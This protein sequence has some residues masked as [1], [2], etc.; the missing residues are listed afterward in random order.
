[1]DALSRLPLNDPDLTSAPDQEGTVFM[2]E[3]LENSISPVTLSTIR[4][5]TSKD[6]VL[7][8]VK[9]MV[10]HGNW[11]AAIE[12]EFLPY[13]RRKR[14]LSVLDDCIVWGSRVVVP[15]PSQKAVLE[16]LHEAHP[17]IVRMKSLARGPV[18][19]PGID[20]DLEEKVKSC[21]PCQ[22]NKKSPPVAPLH[23]WEFPGR[24]WSRL[25]ID[26]AGPFL[27]KMF[28]VLVDA[29]SKWLEVAAVPS[30]SA[31]SVIRFLRTVFAT[32][33]LPDQIVS[34]NGTAFTSD[35]FQ[36]FLKKNAIRHTTSAPYHPAS[37][38]LAERC[39]QT[40]KEA[41]IKSKGDIETC[42][43]RFLFAYRLTP[44]TTT[45]HSPAELLL[46]R[47]PRS[48][49]D[50]IHPDLEEKVAR[51]QEQ[52]KTAPDCHAKRRE[53]SIGDKVYIKNYSGSPEWLPG[54]VSKS[55]GPVSILVDLGDGRQWRRHLDQVRIRS[56]DDV[57]VPGERR[58]NPVDKTPKTVERE[59][60]KSPPGE[61]FNR[62]VSQVQ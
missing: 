4:G 56:V 50:A 16:I 32:H 35:E 25:H 26:F 61:E 62:A 6:P 30:C 60:W 11:D 37:N 17:G 28:I 44:H 24:A 10:T 57:V 19:W 12:Q 40:F 42:L 18:W 46:G 9:N 33:G 5:Q 3:V 43:N 58:P 31:S 52:Q 15:R 29:H 22:E 39:V 45:G 59:K 51:S 23:P 13:L 48:V 20:S 7:S 1:M 47:K 34:D 49:L 14:E 41:L 53:F 8:R 2:L 54:V 27:G 55:T 38:G 36:A 21:K